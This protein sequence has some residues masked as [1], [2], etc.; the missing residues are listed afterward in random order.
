MK[1]PNDYQQYYVADNIM[2]GHPEYNPD[3]WKNGGVKFEPELV[4]KMKLDKPF[5]EPHITVQSAEEAYKSVIADVGPNYPKLDSIDTRAIHDTVNRTTTFKGSKTGLP[6]IID[7]QR[8]VGIYPD[9]KGGEAPADTDHDG[10]S[11]V[12]ETS[13]ALIPTDPS[14]GAKDSVGDGYTNL[15]RYLNSIPKAPA[16]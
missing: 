1:L 13:H 2:E 5:C 6:G 9:L 12:W 8:D 10:M 7:S 14:D 15:E 3:N 11:D 4:D 16:Q